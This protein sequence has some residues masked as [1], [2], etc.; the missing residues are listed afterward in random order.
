MTFKPMHLQFYSVC[1][2]LY[3]MENYALHKENECAIW[4]SVSKKGTSEAIDRM[5]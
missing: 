4:Y 3:R 5:S 1:R 2:G